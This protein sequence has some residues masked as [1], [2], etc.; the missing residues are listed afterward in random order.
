M[1]KA[2]AEEDKKRTMM[3]VMHLGP[4][5]KKFVQLA[6]PDIP[7][8]TLSEDAKVALGTSDL[9]YRQLVSWDRGY[10]DIYLVNLADGSR[11][12]VLEKSPHGAP[13]SP[14]GQWLLYFNDEDRNY[15]HATGS[16]TGRR[17]T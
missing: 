11:K 7:E 14:G 9:P 15:Y 5:E 6:T 8:I 1:Q 4:K 3:C 16:R 17:S 2:Q 13:I 12:K 10:E